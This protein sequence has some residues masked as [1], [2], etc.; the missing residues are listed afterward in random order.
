MLLLT[1]AEFAHRFW[2]TLRLAQR[3]LRRFADE[4]RKNYASGKQGECLMPIRASP[5]EKNEVAGPIRQTFC[6]QDGIAHVL[7]T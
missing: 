6:S 2:T 4:M 5:P 1:N 7:R 3:H